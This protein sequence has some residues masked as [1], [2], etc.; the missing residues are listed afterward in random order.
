MPKK[1]TKQQKR[2]PIQELILR[3]ELALENTL[4]E[5]EGFSDVI[6]QNEIKCLQCG[7]VIFS[8]HRHD[9]KLCGCGKV[10][11]D[12]GQVYL[13][14]IGNKEDY[15]DLSIVIKYHE[16]KSLLTEIHQHMFI[17]PKNQLGI[18]CAIMRTL[19]DMGRLR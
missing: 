2:S 18:L 14:R 17:T 6:L 3:Y 8:R 13:R 4:K 5:F 19:R 10:G 1:E 12:G 11:V 9:Y 16:L 15:K 7:D